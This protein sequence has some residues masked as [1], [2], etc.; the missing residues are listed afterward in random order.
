[1]SGIVE[2]RGIGKDGMES[3]RVRVFA[4]RVNGKVHW[5][6]RTVHGSKRTAQ[7]ELAKLV[8]EV[9]Q[10]QVSAGHPISLG[11]L[12]ERW[13]AD[14]SPHRSAYTDQEFRRIFEANIRPS[15]G[16]VKLDQ[17]V[18]EPDRVNTFYRELTKRG[19]APAS[20]CGGITRFSTRRWA[21]LS[22]GG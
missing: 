14:I 5:V 15:L 6:S 16:S 11:E 10:G 12:I 19:L 21:E 22:S 20:V 18:K 8:T 3:W 7:K 13:L 2:K 1:M 4:G 9:E 17:L